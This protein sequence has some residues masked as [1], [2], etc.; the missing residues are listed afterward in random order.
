MFK[1][2]V[3]QLS[4]RGRALK[5]LAAREHSRAELRTKLLAHGLP[6]AVD[7]LLDELQ[8]KDWLSDERAAASLA[9]RRAPKLGVARVAAE[10]RARGVEAP[11]ME[12]ALAPLREDEFSRALDVWRKKFGRDTAQASPADWA[13]QQRFLLGRGFSS[14]ISSRVLREARKNGSDQPAQ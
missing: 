4:L 6:E 13:R 14:E 2:G 11:A 3:A 5:H 10:M 12:A 7:A 8:A 1:P 9:H